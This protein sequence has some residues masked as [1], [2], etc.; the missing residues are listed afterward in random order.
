MVNLD[1]SKYSIVT[2]NEVHSTNS[3]ALDNLPFLDNRTVIFTTCQTSGRG[4]YNRKWVCDNSENIYMSIVLK[5]DNISDF[6]FPNLTQYLSIALCNVLEKD[7]SLNPVIKWPNDI[8]VEGAKISGILAESYME[9]NT[10][11][12]IVLGL[13]L[14]VNMEKET[15]EKI[16]QKATSIFALTGKNYDCETITRKICDEFFLNYDKFVKEGFSFI[17]DKY[18]QKCFFLGKNIK[19]SENGEKKEYFAEAIDENGFLTVKDELNNISKI[20]TGDVLC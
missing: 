11:K 2:L 17:K 4:R 20:I 5:P 12:G 3:Y 14:N 6:P 1:M 13:G 7:F 8:L 19:I 16:D 15:L 9:N 18:I 10:V